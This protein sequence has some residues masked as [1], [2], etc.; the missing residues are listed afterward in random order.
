MTNICATDL[1]VESDWDIERGRPNV[2]Y[3]TTLAKLCNP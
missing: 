1:F 2:S 3:A